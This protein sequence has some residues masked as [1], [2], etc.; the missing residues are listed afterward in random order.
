MELVLETS[1]LQGRPW[2]G[3][4]ILL[5]KKFS[6][7][8]RFQKSNDRFT[9]VVLDKTIL[10]SLYLPSPGNQVDNDI[11]L[12]T[13]SEIETSICEFPGYSVICGDDMNVDLRTNISS[14]KTYSLFNF[15]NHF[16]LFSIDIM[17]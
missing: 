5:K 2:G 3:V 1:V 8:I 13:L 17:V 11:I 10:I 4:G 7:L 12:S 6:N 15:I 9:I 14:A 16:S